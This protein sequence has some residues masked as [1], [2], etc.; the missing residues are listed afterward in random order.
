MYNL[1]IRT[2]TNNYVIGKLGVQH[3]Y[4]RGSELEAGSLVTGDSD[5]DEDDLEDYDLYDAMGY[6]T[7]AWDSSNAT[8]T[9]G[10]DIY[11]YVESYKSVLRD[12]Y[13]L[14]VASARVPNKTEI[15]ACFG[16]VIKERETHGYIESLGEQCEDSDFYSSNVSECNAND[17]L[18]PCAYWLNTSYWVDDADGSYQHGM[19][20]SGYYAKVPISEYRKYGVRPIIYVNK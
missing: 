2:S 20:Y 11:G 8:Y 10:T 12:E 18:K 17:A 13:H 5:I 3:K 9:S 1:N 16:S 15:A 14:D 19:S 4:V 6:G 7:V